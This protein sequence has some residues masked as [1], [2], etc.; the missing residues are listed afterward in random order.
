MTTAPEALAYFLSEQIRLLAAQGYEVHSVSSPGLDEVTGGR[1]LDSAHHQIPM[2]RTISPIKDLQSL[3]FIWRLFL[4]IRPDIVQTHTP[5]AGL[6]GMIAACCARV[7]VRIYTIN[8]LPI[9]VQGPLG[10]VVLSFTERLACALS[11]EV[12]C[13]SRSVRRLAIGY[14]FCGKEKCRVLGDGGS[15]GVDIHRFDGQLRGARDRGA[16]RRK[17]GIPDDAV[18]IGYI[19]RIVPAKGINELAVAWN[20]LRGNCQQTRLLLCGYREPD[21]PMDGDL[22]E[23]LRADPRVHIT[24]ERVLDMPSMYAAMDIV[25]LPTYCEGLPN[26]VLEAGAMRLPVI[27][28]RVPGCVDAV[29]DGITGLLVPPKN[30]EALADA[31][32]S[33]IEDPER[34]N[35]MGRAARNFIA[36]RFSEAR[37]SHLVLTKYT[38]LMSSIKGR[39]AEMPLPGV[40]QPVTGNP[41]AASE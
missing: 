24:G 27:A 6:L 38:E 33:L 41:A 26:V 40:D 3:Y 20:L 39:S 28:T 14:R 9:R 15:H 21:H 2:R 29:R 11:T 30:G 18:V 37:I 22:F 5:K 32:K 31:L 16:V 35:D 23:Q 25:V 13:V 7:P 34:R 36:K 1:S 19:G 10:A 8:G 12:V 17:Y 4:K